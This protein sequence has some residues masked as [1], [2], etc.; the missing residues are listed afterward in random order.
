MNELY[1]S[2]LAEARLFHLSVIYRK[3]PWIY[4]YL[5]NCSP[6]PTG[7]EPPENHLHPIRIDPRVPTGFRG[8]RAL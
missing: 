7:I 3:T 5:S 6:L 1:E 2:I 8:L 4:L